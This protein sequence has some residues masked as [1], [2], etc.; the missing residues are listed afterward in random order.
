MSSEC[1]LCT[2]FP[3]RFGL[4]S[5]PWFSK[6]FFFL[7]IFRLGSLSMSQQFFPLLSLNSSH[8]NTDENNYLQISGYFILKTCHQNQFP[9]T[10]LSHLE[11]MQNRTRGGGPH[12]HSISECH[13]RFITAGSPF[14]SGSGPN[15]FFLHDLFGSSLNL[16]QHVGVHLKGKEDLCPPAVCSRKP[17]RF[18]LGSW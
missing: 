3:V 4:G 16:T 5:W 6:I 8:P 9:P 7:H 17:V 2:R 15:G 14:D 18:G 1:G 10:H 12:L 13:F 11:Y